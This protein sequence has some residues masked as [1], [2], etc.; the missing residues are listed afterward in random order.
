MS[1]SSSLSPSS[2][3][4]SLSRESCRDGDCQQNFTNPS[5]D[6]LWQYRIG[7]LLRP[8]GACSVKPAIRKDYLAVYVRN[9]EKS[10]PESEEE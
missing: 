8:S 9:D 7:S 6:P 4:R 3:H 2:R 1:Q 10:W 5:S